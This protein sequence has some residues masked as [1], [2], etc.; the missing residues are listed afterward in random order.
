MTPETEPSFLMSIIPLF[1]VG[2]IWAAV[3]LW[4][5]PRKGKPRWFAAVMLIP[6]IGPFGI[7]YLL[8]LTDKKVLDEI[9]ELKR[10]LREK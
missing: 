9:A 7:L 10:S 2:I 6:L 8:A 5:A 1:I 3:A 4:L